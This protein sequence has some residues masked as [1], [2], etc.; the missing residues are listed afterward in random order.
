MIF[1]LQGQSSAP[2]V[3]GLSIFL[4]TIARKTGDIK[5]PAIIRY[6]HAGESRHPG[7]SESGIFLDPGFHRGDEFFYI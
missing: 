1:L 3:T 2:S 6:R 5:S 4:F 7:F